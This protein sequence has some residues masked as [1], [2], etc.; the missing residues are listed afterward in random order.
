MHAMVGGAPQLGQGTF[1]AGEGVGFVLRGFFPVFLVFMPQMKTQL[2][3][4][5]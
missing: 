1:N 4:A 5:A 2:S 3:V